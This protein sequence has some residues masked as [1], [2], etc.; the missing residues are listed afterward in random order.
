MIHVTFNYAENRLNHTLEDREQ[1]ILLKKEKVASVLEFA[2]NKL[3]VATEF[4]LIIFH[5]GESV[6]VYDGWEQD[7]PF[8]AA[9]ERVKILNRDPGKQTYQEMWLTNK[10]RNPLGHFSILPRFDYDLFPFITC[11]SAKGIILINLKENYAETLIDAT[12]TCAWG[13]PS[14]FF[15]REGNGMCMHFTI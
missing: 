11:T 8:V 9:N 6:R 12:S 15:T 14:L 2:V 5:E 13:Q 10:D 1:A 4:S 7:M 3:I